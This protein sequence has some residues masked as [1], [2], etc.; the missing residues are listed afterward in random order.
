MTPGTGRAWPIAIVG[1][2]TLVVALNAALLFVANDDDSAVVEPDYYRRAVNWDSTLSARDR[3]LALGWS[4]GLELGPLQTR[5]VMVS[6]RLFDRAEHPIRDAEIDIVAIHNRDAA[7]Q[8]HG[9]LEADAG[10]G[11]RGLVALHRP[12]IWELRIAAR[13]GNSEWH[14]TVR[15]E[16]PRP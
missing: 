4:A 10:G 5:G 7:R 3:D 13:R 9:R 15:R 2:L 6:A 16:V 1:V 8:V 12:G 11:Y 14:E